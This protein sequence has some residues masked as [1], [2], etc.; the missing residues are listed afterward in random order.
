[1]TR[2]SLPVFFSESSRHPPAT[3]RLLWA[4]AQ[5]D[6][7][8]VEPRKENLRND[9]LHF[10][11]TSKGCFDLSF[12]FSKN[13]IPM[14]FKQKCTNKKELQKVSYPDFSASSFFL[15]FVLQS[16]DGG[17]FPGPVPPFCPS[18]DLMK[19]ICRV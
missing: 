4:N 3:F 8:V 14:N 5:R 2:F 6:L 12:H 17:H 11:F 15:D 10:L 19:D 9:R 7:Y 16:S 13:C 18:L 1:M